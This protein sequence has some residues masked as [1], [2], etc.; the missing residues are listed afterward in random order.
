M[1]V[2]INYRSIFEKKKSVNLVLFVDDT[3]N[4]SGLKKHIS[5]KE[6]AFIEDLQKVSNNKSK[7]LPYDIN[8]KKKIILISVKKNLKILIMKV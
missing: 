2:E 5:D 4:I 6:F 3:L 8:S 7:I 1:S